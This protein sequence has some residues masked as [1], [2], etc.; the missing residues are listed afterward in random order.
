M[1]I[2]HEIRS[3]ANRVSHYGEHLAGRAGHLL[4]RGVDRVGDGLGTAVRGAGHLLA[5]GLE[6]LGVDE[7]AGDLRHHSHKSGQH[8]DNAVDRGGEIAGAAVAG[9]A[10]S[11]AAMPANLAQ[12]A[13]DPLETARDLVSVAR[14]PHVIV[15]YYQ[16]RVQDKGV[17]FT[18]AEGLTDVL[19]PGKVL[20]LSKVVKLGKLSTLARLGGTAEDIASVSQW[21]P[22]QADGYLLMK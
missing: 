4:Q 8:V 19:G 3:A 21:A 9:V 18:V 17:A 12:I 1:N 5:D 7:F 10:T 15:E 16:D 11:V 22:R 2:G 6:H 13:T 20:G 14:N